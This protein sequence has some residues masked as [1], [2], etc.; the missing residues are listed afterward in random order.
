MAESIKVPSRPDETLAAVREMS[1]ENVHKCMQCG[2]CAGLCPMFSTGKLDASPRRVLHLLQ[3]GMLAQV[4]GLVTPW[5]CASCYD[6]EARCP[7]GVDLPRVMEAI[8]QLALRHGES[9]LDPI[10]PFPA[11]V[12]AEAPQLAMVAAF[13]KLTP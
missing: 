11:A 2:Q 6:C 7:R 8:R 9:R 13:R 4:L 10:H 3:A 12:L 1:G 5:T